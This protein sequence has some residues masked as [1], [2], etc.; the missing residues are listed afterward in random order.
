MSSSFSKRTGD[1]C[2]ILFCKKSHQE[3]EIT[4]NSRGWPHPSP[5]LTMPTA[6]KVPSGFRCTRGLKCCH[7]NRIYTTKSLVQKKNRCSNL[8]L[9]PA[10]ASLPP[11]CKSCVLT[12]KF[13]WGHGAISRCH[14][15][16]VRGSKTIFTGHDQASY[17]I[18]VQHTPLSVHRTIDWSTDICLRGVRA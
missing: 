13:L 18:Q 14:R 15:R 3:T 10:H 8:P 17:Q 7:K 11:M 6:V 12:L 16:Y 2:G 4:P 9:S 1:C 5:K